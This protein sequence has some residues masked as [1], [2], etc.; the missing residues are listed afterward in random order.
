MHVVVIPDGNRRYN[1]VHNL[2]DYD[3]SLD[4]LKTLIH[5][6]RNHSSVSE[7]SLFC[8]SSENWKR[9]EEEIVVAMDYLLRFLKTIY[10]NKDPLVL[11]ECFSSSLDKLSVPIRDLMRDINEE[12][13]RLSV[14]SEKSLKVY[15]YISYGFHEETETMHRGYLNS[16]ILPHSQPDLLIRTSGERRI[17]NMCMWHLAYTELMFIDEFFPECTELTWNRCIENYKTRSRRF[18]V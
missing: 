17:S 8:W 16:T 4:A 5:W 6:A 11:Y 7:L 1:R 15:L 13:R 18:G 9:S 12:A 3:K 10:E 14:E 2:I